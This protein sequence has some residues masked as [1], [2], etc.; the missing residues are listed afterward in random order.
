ML[1]GGVIAIPF[2]FLAS[3]YS[4]LSFLCRGLFLSLVLSSPHLTSPSHPST[5]STSQPHSSTLRN[6][7]ILLGSAPLSP[8]GRDS[9]ALALLSIWYVPEHHNRSPSAF[10]AVLIQSPGLTIALL[11]P[12]ITYQFPINSSARSAYSSCITFLTFSG[13]FFY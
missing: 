8:T 7:F 2:T 9:R 6:T 4:L 3:P 11:F 1:G 5:L 12:S 13:A 10:V